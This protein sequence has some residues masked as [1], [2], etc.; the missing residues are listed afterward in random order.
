MISVALSAGSL[1]NIGFEVGLE[2]LG[3]KVCVQPLCHTRR[4][5]EASIVAKASGFKSV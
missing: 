4:I 3:G 2:G 5:I 1:A